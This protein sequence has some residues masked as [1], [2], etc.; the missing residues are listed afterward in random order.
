MKPCGYKISLHLS[1]AAGDNYDPMGVR[2]QARRGQTQTIA[3]V[4][5][6][7]WC[8]MYANWVGNPG[9]K[10]FACGR[11]QPSTRPL[12]LLRTWLEQPPQNR[13]IFRNYARYHRILS[14]CHSWLHSP[15]PPS[16][17]LART[18]QTR[19]SANTSSLSSRP[20]SRPSLGLRSPWK[21]ERTRL[22]QAGSWCLARPE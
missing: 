13:L 5:C 18:A 14:H 10:P 21:N 19:P 7:I 20:S 6:M 9:H 16:V 22:P 3:Q 12:R 17:R 2:C 8:P 1:R 15:L 11:I 4:C